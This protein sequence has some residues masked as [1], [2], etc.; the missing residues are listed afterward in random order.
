[1]PEAIPI[2][3]DLLLAL[4]FLLLAVV[5]FGL[6]QLMGHLFQ[7]V[8]LIGNTVAGAVESAT[9]DA[10]RWLV[11]GAKGTWRNLIALSGSIL[12]LLFAVR[13]VFFQGLNNLVVH[14][15]W[16]EQHGLG[17]AISSAETT[18][19]N[20]LSAAVTTID[21]T[22]NTIAHNVAVVGG[23]VSGI[24]LHGIP[25]AVEAAEDYAQTAAS[26]ALQDAHNFTTTAVKALGTTLTSDLSTVWNAI[27][28]LETAIAVTLPDDI[29]KVATNAASA[30][31]AATQAEAAALTSEAT[32]L[33]GQIQ[34]AIATGASALAAGLAAQQHALTSAVATI[35][36]TIQIEEANLNAL[37]GVVDITLPASIAAIASQVA[38]IT[39]EYEDCAVTSCDG[40]N[41]ISNVLKGLW[42]AFSIAGEL[43]FLAAAI[44]DPKGTALAIDSALNG[45]ATVGKDTLDTLLA[46]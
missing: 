3:G 1:M 21:D 5:I 12:W 41:N 22:T 13:Q 2:L 14:V 19:H 45:A 25:N 39:T 42:S 27:H 46:L 8:P 9:G 44:E 35:D 37:S 11:N 29:T 31:R 6:G 33:E 10:A 38:A 24:L 28:P 23:E 26:N 34:A 20:A 4:I 32:K 36:N 17:Q 30:L 40:P 15:L 16:V 7:Q 43:G 18:A